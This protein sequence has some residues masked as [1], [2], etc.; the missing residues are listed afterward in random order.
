MTGIVPET[1][2][3]TVD[4]DPVVEMLVPP[5]T[6][7]TPAD[8]TAVPDP[9]TKLVGTLEEVDIVKVAVGLVFVPTTFTEVP[10]PMILILPASGTTVG[11]LFPVKVSKVPDDPPNMTHSATPRALLT[12]MYAFAFSVSIQIVGTSNLLKEDVGGNVLFNEGTATC[13]V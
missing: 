1:L 2:M 4:P 10:S 9:V 5:A 7:R 6:V 8:G 11:P 12:R 3:V 13:P